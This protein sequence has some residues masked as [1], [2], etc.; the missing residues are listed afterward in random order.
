M[1]SPKPKNNPR[2]FRLDNAA[3]I[4]PA[5]MSPDWGAVFSLSCSLDEEV[6]P[7][8]LDAAVARALRRFPAFA[9]SLRRGLFWFYHEA[10][11]GH[12]PVGPET[13]VVCGMPRA[14]DNGEFLFRV[15][16]HRERI[17]LE[18]FHSLAD[19]SGA[20][21]F[22]KTIAAC[23]YAG[24]GLPIVA[25]EGVLDPDEAPSP[26]ESEDAFARFAGPAAGGSF[27][28]GRAYCLPGPAMPAP[29]LRVVT[30]V[31]DA[32]E[33]AARAKE[34]SATVTGLL[35][36]LLMLSYDAVQ[37]GEDGLPQ[38]PV[39]I[40]VP[41][42][43]RKLH[44]SKTLRNFSLYANVALPLR[45][46]PPSL[47]EAVA[48]AMDGMRKGHDPEALARM[49]ALNVA[50]ERH[51]ALGPVPLAAKKAVLKAAYAFVG[52]NQ[53]TCALSNLGAVSLPGALGGRVRRFGFALGPSRL[54]TVNLGVVGY[55]GK[56][57]ATT[58]SNVPKPDVEREF[59]RRLAGLGIGVLVESNERGES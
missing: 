10:L 13:S 21:S 27:S 58:T 35:A 7:A 34:R 30:G 47:E 46:E 28:E 17:T 37:R 50:A 52:D 26:E 22:L 42:N 12:P 44:P 6:D 3:K 59:F 19:G 56:I 29:G 57:V 5:V 31:M 11:D 4:Y 18:L 23:Y 38:L 48:A 2:W 51:P 20:L 16:Y 8:I 39:K 55:G 53:F 25:G 15:R 14:S 49:M 54:P 43:M 33:V 9:V 1:P 32:A 41:V 40:Q 36:A 24:R 45:D